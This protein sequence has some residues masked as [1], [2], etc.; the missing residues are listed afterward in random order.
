MSFR[1]TADRRARGSRPSAA[2]DRDAV[3]RTGLPSTTRL[4]AVGLLAVGL[5][6]TLAA[7][8]YPAFALLRYHTFQS[9]SDG[10]VLFLQLRSSGPAPR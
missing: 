9:A 7:A 3:P 6:A 8:A 10:L 1:V 5:L 4:L 2:G